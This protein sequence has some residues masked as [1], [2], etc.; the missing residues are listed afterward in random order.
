MEIIRS[1]KLFLHKL[2]HVNRSVP[3]WC[4]F[5]YF[6]FLQMGWAW[7]NIYITP[8]SKMHF[9]DSPRNAKYCSWVW[10][11]NC[12][13]QEAASVQRPQRHTRTLQGGI[14]CFFVFCFFEEPSLELH[15]SPSNP[16]QASALFYPRPPSSWMENSTQQFNIA[17]RDKS[18]LFLMVTD[19]ITVL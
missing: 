9:P 5:F 14:H 18:M 12:N 3:K 1:T 11:S 2:V 15:N 6:F 8:L 13:F 10:R 19:K 4:Q 16:F 7:I 17:S